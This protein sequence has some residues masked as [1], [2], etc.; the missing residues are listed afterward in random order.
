[1][2]TLVYT[3]A[4]NGY[5]RIWSRC[6]NSQKKY[7]DM[8]GAEF[9]VVAEPRIIRVPALSAWLKVPLMNGALGNGYEWVA[10]IDADCEVKPGTPDFRS[11]LG[12]TTGGSVFMANGRSGR[13]NSGVMFARNEPAATMFYSRVLESLTEDIPD[14]ARAG[15][16]YEN[17]NIIYC[18]AKDASVVEIG[19]EWNNSYDSSIEEYIRHYT[20]PFRD[21]YKLSLMNRLYSSLMKNVI[22]RPS[23]Q[24]IRRDAEFQNQLELLVASC[25]KRHPE[26][27]GGNG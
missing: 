6:I 13:L 10:Y 25:Q 27:G 1:M 16:K 24:P 9:V 3:I 15:L 7:A 22:A 11:V 19:T 2:T 8:I 20:G 17:G 23:Q 12:A 14:E 26:F 21:E 4:Q 5:D 18:A